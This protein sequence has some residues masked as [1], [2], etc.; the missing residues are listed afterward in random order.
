MGPEFSRVLEI[1]PVSGAVVWRYQGTPVDTFFSPRISGAQ[2][3][4]NG[5]TFI[6]ESTSGY[7][8][9]VDSSGNTVW[10]YQATDEV[11]RAL[12]YSAD[13]AG[14]NVVLNQ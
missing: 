6:A 8:F 3:L 10:F 5:N 1:D 7:L 9:E 12:Q 11:A 13:H 14:I 2:R 4:A